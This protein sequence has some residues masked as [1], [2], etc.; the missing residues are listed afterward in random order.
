MHNTECFEKDAVLRSLLPGIDLLDI[1][2]RSLKKSDHIK[3]YTVC[4]PDEEFSFL[5]ESA[6]V[7]FHGR[8]IAAWYNNRKYELRGYTPI[9]FAFSDNDG[10]DWSEPKTVI[11]DK[12]EKILYCPPVFGID[13]DKLYML[14]NQMV[15][16]DHMHS[17]D[18][19]IYNE[20]DNR[21]DFVWTREIPFKLN[22]NVYKMEN[23]KLILPGRIAKQDD[24]PQIP[25]V[26]ISDTGRID[27]EWRLVKVQDTKKLPDG[28]ELIH[29]E[30][31]LIID[32][33]KIY[34]FCRNDQRKVPLLFKSDDWGEHW[35]GPFAS[36]I[37]FSGAKIYSGT[38]SD[39][40]N[41]V[42]GNLDEERE[43]LYILFSLK[44]EMKFNKGYILQKVFSEELGYG[45][46]WAYPCAYEADGKLYVVYTAVVD[47]NYRRGAVISVIDL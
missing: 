13:N 11:G 29:P 6:I 20:D 15:S 17:L 46:Q 30:L 39:G 38:L 41:Y 4:M 22:T 12:D 43:I 5:H 35:T 36:D 34:G 1:D 21:F 32:K 45:C 19:Y 33:N 10:V 37:P 47:K 25:A 2:I 23:G 42:I 8:L 7:K 9:R 28:S 26:L 16:A 31:S 40:R 18:L 27:A 24:F 44:G 3:S 14:L